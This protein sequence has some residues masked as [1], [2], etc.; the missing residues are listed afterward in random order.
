VTSAARPGPCGRQ[1][2][3][4]APQRQEPDLLAVQLAKGLRAIR[5][6]DAGTGSPCRAVAAGFGD[7]RRL[8]ALQ[9]PLGGSAAQPRA[10]HDALGGDEGGAAALVIA[11]LVVADAVVAA[12][13]HGGESDQAVPVGKDGQVRGLAAHSRQR[14]AR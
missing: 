7:A 9:G 13:R 12:Q 6:E 5:C 14:S 1:P 2:A 11:H 8:Q 3:P 4:G 10:S